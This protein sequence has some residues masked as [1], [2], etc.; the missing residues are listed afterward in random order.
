MQELINKYEELTDGAKTRSPSIRGRE[1]QRMIMWLV[2]HTTFLLFK[3]HRL[4]R[5]HS[6][7]QGEPWDLGPLVQT[8]KALAAKARVVRMVKICMVGD[9]CGAWGISLG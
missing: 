3:E 2:V 1:K 6:D 7:P 4:R 5:L 9:R 8:A